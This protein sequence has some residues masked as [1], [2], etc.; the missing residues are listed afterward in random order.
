ME[1]ARLG[2]KDVAEPARQGELV[3]C[4]QGSSLER[5]ITNGAN[6]LPEMARI[7]YVEPGD[8]PPDSQAIYDFMAQS[9]GRIA[10]FAKILG[11][12]PWILRFLYP[13]NLVLQRQGSCRTD[14][15]LRALGILKAALLNRC[16]Y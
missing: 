5:T 2:G 13:L 11:H 7:S 3:G 14:V 9:G 1:L 4:A 6:R 15:R 8:A 16:Q 12:T 10:N